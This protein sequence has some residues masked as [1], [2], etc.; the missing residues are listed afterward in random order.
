MLTK[1]IEQA[2][3]FN[4]LAIPVAVVTLFLM[5]TI[6]SAV[7][8]SDNFASLDSEEEL[9]TLQTGS[10][11]DEDQPSTGSIGQLMFSDDNGYLLL[12]EVAGTLLLASVI[13]AMVLA[14]ERE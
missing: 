14:R 4:K 9:N 12:F 10:T 8:D 6:I 1:D 7:A 2:N 5:I 3:R 13:G 11:I